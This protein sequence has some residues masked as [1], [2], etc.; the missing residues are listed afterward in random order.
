MTYGLLMAAM[1]AAAPALEVPG[2]IDAVEVDAPL[3]AGGVPV[4]ATLVRS[5]K[6]VASLARHFEELFVARGLFVPPTRPARTALIVA[7]V[8]PERL[9]AWTVHLRP[10]AS[11]GTAVLLGR[12]D[13]TGLRSARPGAEGVPLFPGASGVVQV[14]VGEGARA[15][16]YRARGTLKEVHAFYAQ[17]VT[18]AGYSAEGD[19]SY[20]RGDERLE[21]FAARTR[22]GD[23][24]VT[25]LRQS[26]TR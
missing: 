12:A 11:G 23:V 9:L 18:A 1:V 16:T 22:A 6:D 7:G 25:I 8:D 17:E 3:Q 2:A 24:A 21:V 13:L 10:L 15:W 26:R 14:A 4:K 19:G 5:S 20:V